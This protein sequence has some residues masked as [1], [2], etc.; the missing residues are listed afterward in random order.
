MKSKSK[1]QWKMYTLIDKDN[2]GNEF[3]LHTGDKGYVQLY[4]REYSDNL[5]MVA[6]VVKEDKKG[7]Y[8]GWIDKGRTDPEMI[9]QG[10]NLFEI[11]FAYG[12][13]A[14]VEAGR[15][16]VVRLKIEKTK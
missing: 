16:E 4:K 14:E 8:Y 6:V 1:R 11:C 5:P 12:S 2:S 10:K 9:W 15:G 13:N 7:E 3:F